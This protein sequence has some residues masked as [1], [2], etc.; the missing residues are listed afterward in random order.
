MEV[1]E[2]D[3]VQYLTIKKKLAP[4]TVETYTIRLRVIKRWLSENSSE[5][6]NHSIETFLFQLKEQGL[7]NAALNT[8]IQTL[9][10][11]DGFC[12][13]RGLSAGFVEGIKTLPKIRPEIIILSVEEI[14]R[15]INTPL[16]YKNRNGVDC[17]DLD[18]KYRTLTHFLALTGCRFEEAASLKVKR[19]DISN[20]IATLVNTKN[21]DNRYVYFNGSIKDDLYYLTK[22]KNPED[23][24]FT[25]SRGQ[26]VNAGDFN[27]DLRLRAKKSGITKR[28][29]AHLLRHSLATQLLLSGVDITM[30]ATL[31]GHRDVQTT[32]E[33]YVHLADET[34]KEAA[35][36]HPM[37]RENVDPQEIIKSVKETLDNLHLETDNRFNFKMIQ[38]GGKLNFELSIR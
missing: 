19:L 33:N 31:L 3:F 9:N 22:D 24:V 7:S 36:K 25:N 11:L 27:N 5:L 1:E 8:Y 26:H 4:K 23:L 14:K 15:L 30:V 6:N 32:F 2:K 16:E 10:H 17:S 13:D 29:H 38:E 20:G 28:V 12:R 34:I 18:K 21:K 35:M 37:M